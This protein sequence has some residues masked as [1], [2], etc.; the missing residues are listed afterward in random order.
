MYMILC[1]CVPITVTARSKA[2]TVFARSNTAVVSWDPTRGMDVCVQVAALRWADP[3]SKESYRLCIGL[4][5]C[6]SGQGPTKGCRA[7][8]EWMNELISHLG[9]MYISQFDQ[10]PY[11]SCK[12]QLATSEIHMCV[13]SSCDATNSHEPPISTARTRTECLS[14]TSRW[15]V[16]VCVMIF[17]PKTDIAQLIYSFRVYINLFQSNIRRSQTQKRERWINSWNKENQIVENRLKR[18]RT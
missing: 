12:G 8:D 13:R 17:I 9:C 5:N 16:Y 1:V 14:N 15:C 2:G 11:V 10:R 7:I 3:P 4:R 18:Y 6:K